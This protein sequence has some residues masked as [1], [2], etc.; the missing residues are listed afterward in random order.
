[1][2]LS[3]PS[4]NNACRTI[5][6]ERSGAASQLIMQQVRRSGLAEGQCDRLAR[7]KAAAICYFQFRVS[8]EWLTVD[9]I[10]LF[11]T[12]YIPRPASAK[13]SN[14]LHATEDVLWERHIIRMR[15]FWALDR[16]LCTTCVKCTQKP[17][18]GHPLGLCTGYVSTRLRTMTVCSPL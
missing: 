7:R 6:S 16:G 18:R 2:D 9:D 8:A 13:K 4:P 14:P 10:V 5:V 3:F 11:I 1:M 12:K 15:S 17:R